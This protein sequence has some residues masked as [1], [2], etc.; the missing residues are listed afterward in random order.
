MKQTDR[1]GNAGRTDKVDAT[2]TRPIDTGVFAIVE[3]ALASEEPTGDTEL[4]AQ[5]RSDRFWKKAE[6]ATRVAAG[7]AGALAALIA[8]LQY[9]QAYDIQR[10]ERSLDFVKEWQS[11][12]L[13]D[14]FAVVQVFVEER[15]SP[16]KASLDV[17]EPPAQKIAVKNLARKWLLENRKRLS[18]QAGAGASVQLAGMAAPGQQ[19]SLEIEDSVDNLVQFF[20]QMQICIKASI[21]DEDVLRQFFS[22]EVS[23]FWSYFSAYAVL[24]QEAGYNDYGAAVDQLVA[25]FEAAGS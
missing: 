10:S 9:M 16:I 5:Q 8:A 23:S 13:D 4:G 12:E 6:R 14:D 24:R 1:T 21:C 3:A 19:P 15:L 18:E 7:F 25:K 2:G 20:S 22:S 11:R 17:L